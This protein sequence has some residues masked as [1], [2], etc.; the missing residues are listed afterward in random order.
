M[1]QPS[2]S[3]HLPIWSDPPYAEQQ[4]ELGTTTATSAAIQSA[5]CIS[6][7]ALRNHA[8]YR[9]YPNPPDRCDSATDMTLPCRVLESLAIPRR[10]F[11]TG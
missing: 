5:F 10:N 1:L 8:S 4:Q 2:P 3:R 7:K 11:A 9:A 6:V